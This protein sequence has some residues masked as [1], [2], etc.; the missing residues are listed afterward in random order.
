MGG[1]RK[2][3]AARIV[4]VLAPP[5]SSENV[6]PASGRKFPGRIAQTSSAICADADRAELKICRLVLPVLRPVHISLRVLCK[7]VGIVES[8]WSNR[9]TIV[10]RFRQIRR[11]DRAARTRAIWRIRKIVHQ[12]VGLKFNVPE[13]TLPD[14]G[15]GES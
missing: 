1:R 15:P 11:G 6:P 7:W 2:T 8:L 14:V 10:L 5:T 12:A 9:S 4:F 13:P 3:G